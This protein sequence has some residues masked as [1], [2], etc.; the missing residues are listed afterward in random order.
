MSDSQESR[1]RSRSRSQDNERKQKGHKKH[2]QS[3]KNKQ[4]DSKSKSNSRSSSNENNKFRNSHK[5]K[6][7]KQSHTVYTVKKNC[8]NYIKGICQKSEYDCE[9]FHPKIQEN[10]ISPEQFDPSLENMNNYSMDEAELYNFCMEF[11]PVKLPTKADQLILIRH[12]LSYY[13]YAAFRFFYQTGISYSDPKSVVYQL[14][15]EYIDAPLHPLGEQMCKNNAKFIQ[16][17]S[18]HTVF[19]SPLRRTLQTA[20][21]LFENHPNKNEIKFI[22]LPY[23]TEI[24]S[25]V[26]DVSDLVKVKQEFQDSQFDFC[27][28]DQFKFS[29]ENWQIENLADEDLKTY[30]RAVINQDSEGKPIK[31]ILLDEC[32]RNFPSS[33]EKHSHQYE[34]TLKTKNYI[35]EYIDQNQIDT[36]VQKIGL[37][38]H[39]GFL[40]SFTSEGKAQNGFVKSGRSF[41]NCEAY[42]FQI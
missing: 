10:P 29:T 15:K 6:H 11:Q 31:E 9:D 14:R 8:I 22:V 3:L 21:I 20:Q 35:L 5:K 16:N 34:R 17:Y 2:Q 33:V 27:L 37:V 23:C 13:N 39:Y 26:C 32:Q 7:S 1:S 19:V 38:S 36:S 28:F 12:A 18:F 41:E 40:S 25:K 24:L 42:P 4:Q 30:L